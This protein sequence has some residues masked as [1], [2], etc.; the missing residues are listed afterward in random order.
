VSGPI[1]RRVAGLPITRYNACCVVVALAL[2][3]GVVTSD[4]FDAD[5]LPPQGLLC[6]AMS[7][8]VVGDD[9]K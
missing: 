1:S 7:I 9:H 8:F 3:A 5:T 2:L 4:S 6:I